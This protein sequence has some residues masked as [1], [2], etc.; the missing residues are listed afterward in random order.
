MKKTEVIERLA[1]KL[2]LPK[3]EVARFV[4][5][6]SN[7]I[8]EVLK[9]GDDVVLDIGKFVKKVRAAREGINPA[10]GAKVKIPAKTVPAFRP[11]KK[12]KEALA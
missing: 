3:K 11:N 2:E 4:D 8:I 9:T 12:F 1:D 6:L 5:E 7:L 10:T